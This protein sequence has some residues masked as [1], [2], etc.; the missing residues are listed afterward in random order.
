M[1]SFFSGKQTDNETKKKYCLG[2]QVRIR[3]MYI[4]SS[5]LH[6]LFRVFQDQRKLSEGLKSSFLCRRGGGGGV[7]PMESFSMCKCAFHEVEIIAQ[8]FHKI[9][10][11]YLSRK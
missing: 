6:V 9:F 8:D 5:W 3:S 2:S 4:H 1:E 10:D 7:S 11:Y